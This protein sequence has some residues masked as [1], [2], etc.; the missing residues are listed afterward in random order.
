VSKIK[1]EMVLGDGLVKAA[2]NANVQNA[3]TVKIGDRKIFLS[4]VDEVIR[5]RNQERG[6]AAL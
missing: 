6:V 5:I 3:G 2:V 1:I 4:K